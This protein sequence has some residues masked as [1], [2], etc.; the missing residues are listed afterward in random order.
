MLIAFV[1]AASAAAQETPDLPKCDPAKVLGDEACAKCHQQEV[2][3][4]RLTPHYRTFD[5]LHRKPEAK[6]IA[7]K[8]GLRSVKRNDTCVRCHYT[9]Q[10]QRGRAR[11]IAGVSCESCHGAAADWV[12]LHADYGGPNVTK[13]MESAEHKKQR[14]Q[15]S[16]AAGMNNPSDIYLI[17]RQCLGCHTTPD[18]QLVNVGGHN[19]GSAGFELVS[20]SQG[21]VRH[22]FQ[23]TDGQSN[24]P[25]SV[26]QLRV[27]YLVGA[28][29]DLEMSLRAVAKATTAANFGQQAAARAARVKQ[30]LWE[31]QRLLDDRLIAK[32]LDAVAELELTLD[33]A[34]AILNAANR[35]G[36]A[37]QEFSKTADGATLAAIDPLLPTADKY[38]N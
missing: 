26:E 35:V 37:A 32:A 13:Q 36:K 38:K 24:A 18:E 22:N 5:I 2:N 9:Q 12:N 6:A 21:I 1:L 29:A 17:A 10:E 16:V 30:R 14:R 27:M 11:V 4:W 31:A 20:W 28:M 25:S 23:R 7:D 15:A 19:A 33:N 8:L 34:D 3:Q